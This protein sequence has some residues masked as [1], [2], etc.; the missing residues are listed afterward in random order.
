MN[1][2]D[3]EVA[4]ENDVI[5]YWQNILG[6][7]INKNPATDPDGSR[8]DVSTTPVYFASHARG[9]VSRKLN[10]ISAGKSIIVPINPV[11]IAQP[12]VPSG[13]VDDCKKHAREDEDSASEASITID[14]GVTFT[15][16]ELQ[17][18]RVHTQ[19]FEVDV[20]ENAI[21][22]TPPGRWKAV[23]DGYYVKIKPL[24]PGP[25]KINFKGKVDR[26]YKED[27]PWFQDITYHFTV[28]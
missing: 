1:D 8:H 19:P 7:P 18:C 9:Q 2:L 10:D 27:A 12:H 21:A 3:F 13:S 22:D 23:A 5:K 6:T 26:P 14:D 4:D 11:S 20:P 24:P 17:R 16:K 28:K 15:L 25:H